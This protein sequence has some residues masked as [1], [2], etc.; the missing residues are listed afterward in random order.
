MPDTEQRKERTRAYWQLE[1]RLHAA[2]RNLAQL[3]DE[4]RRLRR[5]LRAYLTREHG[6]RKH[7]HDPDCPACQ[8]VR[9]GADT[10]A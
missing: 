1:D 8:M 10:D 9:R 5:R 7:V 4:N 6:Q 3:R 2:E